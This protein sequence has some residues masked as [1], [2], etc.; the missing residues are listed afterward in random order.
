LHR[1]ILRVVWLGLVACAA[2]SR[3]ATPQPTAAPTEPRETPPAHA[4]AVGDEPSIA[5]PEARAPVTT[6]EAHAPIDDVPAASAYDRSDWPH[7]ID[8]DRD[9][10]DTRTEVLLAE[11]EPDSVV[12]ADPRRCAIARG[13]WRCPYTGRVVTDPRALDVDHLVPLAHAHAAGGHAWSRERR[14]AYANDLGDPDHLVV[15]VAGANRSKGQRSIVQ[16]LPPDDANRCVY[17]AAWIAVKAR[18]GLQVDAEERAAADAFAADCRE[19]RI[20][21]LAAELA[22]PAADEPGAACCRVCRSG[23]PCGDSCIAADKTCRK[24]PGCA[25]R[26]AG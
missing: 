8:A 13:R 20:P 15:V 14:T 5:T 18:W 21:R 9:C 3:T 16:W 17:V 7:W 1:S 6:P 11:A 2:P 23:Q 4:D 24:P 12:F 26:S 10:Q 25:C 22:D 19:G